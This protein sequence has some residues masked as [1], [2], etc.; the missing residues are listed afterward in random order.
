VQPGARFPS[1]LDACEAFTDARTGTI[2][3]A[4]ENEKTL[5]ARMA[6]H[7]RLGA[8]SGDEM[9]IFIAAHTQRHADQIR[10]ILQIRSSG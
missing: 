8:L 3:F 4:T 10:E 9:L 1:L 6:D 5:S 7:P 2:Q